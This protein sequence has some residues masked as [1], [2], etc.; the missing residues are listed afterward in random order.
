MVNYDVS[1]VEVGLEFEG[2]G[3]YSYPYAIGSCVYRGQEFSFMVVEGHCIS[4]E[5]VKPENAFFSVWIEDRNGTV[6]NPVPDWA[7]AND[8]YF[9]EPYY[10][11]IERLLDKTKEILCFKEM[12]WMLAHYNC[13]MKGQD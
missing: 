12:M 9:D 6:I 4:N 11:R 1:D 7:K 5:L 2:D 10:Y 13:Q 3:P 8:V